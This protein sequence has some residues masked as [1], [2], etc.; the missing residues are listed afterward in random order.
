MRTCGIHRM[1]RVGGTSK[2][3]PSV[4][5]RGE[6]HLRLEVEPAVMWGLASEDVAFVLN[7]PRVGDDDPAANLVRRLETGAALLEEMRLEVGV[8]VRHRWHC[9]LVVPAG[10]SSRGHVFVTRSVCARVGVNT[11]HTAGGVAYHVYSAM[12]CHGITRR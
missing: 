9:R 3:R 6:R 8:G 5:P 12:Y 10:D 4:R 1:T 11:L 7:L 2:F